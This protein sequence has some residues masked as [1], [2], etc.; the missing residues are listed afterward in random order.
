MRKAFIFFIVFFIAAEGF[1]APKKG[2]TAHVGTEH[3]FYN[4][5]MNFRIVWKGIAAG[6][7][8]LRS[9]VVDKDFIQINSR[10]NSLQAVRGIYYVQGVFA[11]K[12]NF[13]TRSPVIAFEEAYQGDSYQRR[14]FRFSGSNAQVE[15]HEMKFH[16]HSYPHST[17][18][19]GDWSDSYSVSTAGGYQDLLGAFYFVRSTGRVP[20]VGE[21]LRVPVLPAGS[22]RSLILKVLG[23]S[24][25]KDVPFFGTREIIHVR[26]ALADDAKNKTNM[27]SNIFFNTKS[28]IEMW[29]TADEDFVP[30]KLWTDVPYLGTAYILLENYSQP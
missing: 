18:P 27:G 28:Q 23:R 17:P 6:D 15:K 29:I 11:S 4:E 2:K 30:V 20:K 10:V 5:T 9:R 7:V 14:K 13:V 19:K 26:S 3:K 1:A 24:V 21:V 25:R 12:W 16:E 22:R 8:T